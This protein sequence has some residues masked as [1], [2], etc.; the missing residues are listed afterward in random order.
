MAAINGVADFRTIRILG[1]DLSEKIK[2]LE[3][4]SAPHVTTE[5]TGIIIAFKR[6]KC[7]VPPQGITYAVKAL[8]FA[9]RIDSAIK[10]N[11]AE[12]A[13]SLTFGFTREYLEVENFRYW[14]SDSSDA[15]AWSFRKKQQ[16]RD[17]SPPLLTPEQQRKA[18]KEIQ[19]LIRKGKCKSQRKACEALAGKYGVGWRTLKR[20]DDAAV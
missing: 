2:E 11:D 5:D 14:K 10:A 9:Y 8:Q 17:A 15:L 12:A 1:F 16:A 18:V 7:F 20:Y 13:V 3:E 19:S 6:K 4:L